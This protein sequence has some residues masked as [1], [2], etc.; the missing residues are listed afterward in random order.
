[1]DFNASQRISGLLPVATLSPISAAL[2]RA[3]YSQGISFSREPGSRGRKRQIQL[4][5]NPVMGLNVHLEHP[6]T[7]LYRVRGGDEQSPVPTR[8]RGRPF[9]GATHEGF[10]AGCSPR[11]SEKKAKPVKNTSSLH[12]SMLGIIASQSTYVNFN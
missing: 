12:V 10:G 1:M 8:Y 4:T 11:M 3:M 6:E 5:P 9:R 2:P 7:V